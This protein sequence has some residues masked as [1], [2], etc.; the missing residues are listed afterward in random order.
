MQS[1]LDSD[2]HHAFAGGVVG[3]LRFAVVGGDEIGNPELGG[4]WRLVGIM[5]TL[6]L[7]LTY[8]PQFFFGGGGKITNDSGETQLLGE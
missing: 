7:V 3:Y 4:T 5:Y 1:P 8:S 2:Q 6:L